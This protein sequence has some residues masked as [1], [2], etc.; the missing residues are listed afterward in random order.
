MAL[1][2][3]FQIEGGW[4]EIDGGTNYGIRAATLARANNL[5]IVETQDIRKLTRNEAAAI[6]YKMF[7]LESGSYKYPYPLNLVMFDAAVHMGPGEA[8]RLLRV[9]VQ[10]TS[11]TKVRPIAQR[12]VVERYKKLRT[13][14]NYPKYRRGWQ[15]RMR[16]I[17]NHVINGRKPNNKK[18][19]VPDSKFSFAA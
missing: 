16:I 9:A 4:T 5:K 18:T 14:K 6:Y 2:I 13:L 1:A 7:W 17:M 19:F 15:K 10:G 8:K 3:I 11:S 12:Y